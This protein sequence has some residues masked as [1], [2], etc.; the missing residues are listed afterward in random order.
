MPLRN[1]TDADI[2]AIA[3]ALRAQEPLTSP[4]VSAVIIE[5]EHTLMPHEI[6]LLKRIVATYNK[7]S[8]AIGNAFMLVIAAAAVAIVLKG[9]WGTIRESLGLQ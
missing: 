3:D 1:L 7:T 9:F 8:N 5:E 2:K 4:P 6:R